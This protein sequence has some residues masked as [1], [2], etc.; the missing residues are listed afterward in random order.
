MIGDFSFDYSSEEESEITQCL[1]SA[2]RSNGQTLQQAKTEALFTR[3][4]MGLSQYPSKYMASVHFLKVDPDFE[5]QLNKARN[6]LKF[7]E[8]VLSEIKLPKKVKAILVEVPC[9]IENNLTRNSQVCEAFVNGEIF[10][11]YDVEHYFAYQLFKRK[12][13]QAKD[14]VERMAPRTTKK[15]ELPMI[16]RKFVRHVME[17]WANTKNMPV[18]NCPIRSDG[19]MIDFIKAVCDPVLLRCHGKKGIPSGRS[20]QAD[21]KSIRE[22]IEKEAK[23]QLI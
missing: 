23:P 2:A 17:V 11:D 5:S 16:R 20:Y 7:L 18:Q 13:D 22:E 21:I 8:C 15:T 3:A 14:I 6:R 9:A 12:V 4:G 19:P 1:V 10:T